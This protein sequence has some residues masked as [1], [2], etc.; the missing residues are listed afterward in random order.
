MLIIR[1][2]EP[3]DVSAIRDLVRAAFAEGPHSDGT[4]PAIVDALRE[5][6]ALTISL[7]AADGAVIVGHVAVSP[8][9]VGG[10][11]GEWF[12]LGPVAVLPGRQR[13][14][15]GGALISKALV[16]LQSSGATGCVV[17]GDPD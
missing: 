4:E 5:G 9:T 14:G 1:S 11:A 6:G 2:E 17:L 7:V 10:D 13:Q 16:R 12:G 15:I 3:R 8:V